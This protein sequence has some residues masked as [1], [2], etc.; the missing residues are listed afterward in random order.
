[1]LAIVYLIAAFSRDWCLS[2]GSGA[3]AEQWGKTAAVAI[4][5]LVGVTFLYLYPH[6]TALDASQALDESLL[7]LQVLVMTCG[8]FPSAALVSLLL[9]REW[10]GRSTADHPL[11]RATCILRGV[12]GD[13]A[14]PGARRVRASGKSTANGRAY[15]PSWLAQ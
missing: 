13:T 1:M 14:I 11:R 15:Q 6:W 3:R 2:T 7:L 8:V 10:T 5:V 12:A 9:L 4:M